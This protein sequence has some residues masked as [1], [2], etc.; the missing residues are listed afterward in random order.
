MDP[1][2]EVLLDL[3]NAKPV[4]SPAAAVTS[5]DVAVAPATN[6]LTSHGR[7]AGC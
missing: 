3:G 6:E 2:F 7:K 4:P 5:H 1:P